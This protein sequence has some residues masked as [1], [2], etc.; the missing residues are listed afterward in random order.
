MNGA[1]VVDAAERELARDPDRSVIVQAPAGSGKTELLMQRY[2]ALLAR[3][4]D[5]HDELRAAREGNHALEEQ[6]RV[7]QG[8]VFFRQ[9][10]ETDGGGLPPN[11]LKKFSR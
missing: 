11:P 10:S 5:L 4:D 6:V 7:L 8:I 2:L 3:V 9:D 1:P